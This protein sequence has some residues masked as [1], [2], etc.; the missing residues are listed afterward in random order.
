MQRPL[1]N[2]GD[3]HAGRVQAR[4]IDPARR[5]QLTSATD[6]EIGHEQ[7]AVQGE[8]RGA[9]ISIASVGDDPAGGLAGSLAPRSLRIGELR[10][11]GRAAQELPRIRDEPLLPPGDIEDPQTT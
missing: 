8:R 6:Q 5:R 9:Q 11:V 1:R 3:A 7:P 2:V 4:I 10:P